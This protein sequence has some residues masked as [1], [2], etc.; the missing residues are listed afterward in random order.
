MHLSDSVRGVG[1]D[2]S[3]TDA[4]CTKTIG[5]TN[6]MEILELQYEGREYT[7]D[8][9][10]ISAIEVEHDIDDFTARPSVFVKIHLP[11]GAITVEMNG[12][13]LSDL[14]LRYR[15]QE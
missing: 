14:M 5:G 8:L 15:S 1:V 6:N 13:E 2:A 10:Q 12:Q 4:S 3:I 7:V 9:S 11:S